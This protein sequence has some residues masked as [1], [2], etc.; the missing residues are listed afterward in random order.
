MKKIITIIIVLTAAAFAQNSIGKVGFLLGEAQFSIE[1]TSQWNSLK[2]NAEIKS[3]YILKTGEDSELEIIW[4]SGGST[5]IGS[6]KIIRIAELRQNQSD[7]SSWADKL[8]S[9]INLVVQAK[10]KGIVQGTA[11]VRMKE[12]EPVEGDS[13]YWAQVETVDFNEGYSAFNEGSF[14]KAVEIFEKLLRQDPFSSEAETALSCLISI[15]YEK[16]E[17]EKAEKRLAELKQN[18]PESAFIQIFNK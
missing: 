3:N 17:L 1:G 12:I 8:K 7:N 14:D 9:K 5:D 16:N 11:G 13:L 15:Y 10:D 2:L 6:N 18:F 4:N